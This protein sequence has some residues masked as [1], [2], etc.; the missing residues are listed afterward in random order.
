MWRFRVSRHCLSRCRRAECWRSP[1]RPDRA[2][3]RLLR[4]LAD[5]DPHRGKRPLGRA[6]VR[7][8]PGPRVAPA[9][10]PASRGTAILAPGGRPA[11]SRRRGLPRRGTRRTPARPGG[12]KRRPG[13]AL[14]GGALPVGAPAAAPERPRGPAA[15]RTHREPRSGQPGARH[16][17]DPPLPQGAGR[18]GGVGFPPSRGGGGRGPVAG[19]AG[20][21]GP[22]PFRSGPGPGGKPRRDP[23]QLL[24]SRRRRGGG[25]AARAGEPDG[26]TRRLPPAPLARRAG[27]G[28]A[29]AAGARASFRARDEPP[30]D[31]RTDGALHA[32]G[33]GAG[34]EDPPGAAAGRT[35]GVSRRGPG[36]VPVLLPVYRFRAG[37]G[38]RSRSLVGAPVLHPAARDAAR[39]HHERGLALH[40][41]A[42]RSGGRAAAR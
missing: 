27:I 36:D 6:L 33:R 21:R 40:R 5:L 22:R 17:A 24:G 32:R 1:V 3:T 26:G 35:L 38:A 31:R 2:K 7:R 20:R 15:R 8:A 39:K 29:P 9:G 34:G 4:A 13:A 23:P 11:L 41:A 30:G 10:R 37:G 25:G 28:A 18:P 16:R 42:H 12:P 14:H 19:S